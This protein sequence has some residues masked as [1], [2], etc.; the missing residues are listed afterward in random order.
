MPFTIPLPPPRWPAW[1]DQDGVVSTAHSFPMHSALAVPKVNTDNQERPFPGCL[2][3]NGGAGHDARGRV[4][5][6]DVQ[7]GQNEQN[8]QNGACDEPSSRTSG[9]ISGGKPE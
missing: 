4:P 5:V 3:F 9:E 6:D 7:N 2:P 8:E 1:L